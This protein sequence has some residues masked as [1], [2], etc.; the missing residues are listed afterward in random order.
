[1]KLNLD[2]PGEDARIEILP[3]I[4]VIFCILTFFILGAVS[5]TRQSAIGVDLPSAETGTPQMREMFLVSLDPIGQLYL[6]QQPISCEQLS[7]ALIRERAINP[8]KLVVL[9]ASRSARYDDVVD[10][11]DLLRSIGGD[12]V[13]LATLP[14]AEETEPTDAFPS[15]FNPDGSLAPDLTTPNLINP[16]LLQPDLDPLRNSPSPGTSPSGATDNNSLLP[17]D[18]NLNPLVPAPSDPSLETTPPQVQ[19]GSTDDG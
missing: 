1:M 14:D 19:P 11:L 16:D 17:D 10:I 2:S 9:Y 3:L 15:P 7:D 6:E 4:D 12:R 18:L 13:A 8:R 5:L